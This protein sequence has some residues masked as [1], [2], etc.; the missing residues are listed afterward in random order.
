MLVL[1]LV[2]VLGVGGG[3]WVGFLVLLLVVLG[4]AAT[5]GGWLLADAEK[6]PGCCKQRNGNG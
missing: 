5:G 2:L 1:V 3:Y 4:V 6:A